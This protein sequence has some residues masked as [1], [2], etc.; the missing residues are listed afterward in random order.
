MEIDFLLI[1]YRIVQDL[2]HAIQLWKI[3]PFS[4]I[5]RFCGEIPPCGRPGVIVP[6]HYQISASVFDSHFQFPFKIRT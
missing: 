5:F 6:Q 3:T 2:F 1:F 4:I